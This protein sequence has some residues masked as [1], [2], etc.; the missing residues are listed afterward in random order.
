VEVDKV[1]NKTIH[2][3]KPKDPFKQLSPMSEKLPPPKE[4]SNNLYNSQLYPEQEHN[5]NY[6]ENLRYM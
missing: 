6:D 1:V 4:I 5:N 2:I 3:I